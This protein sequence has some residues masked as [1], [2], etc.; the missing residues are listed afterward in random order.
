MG[1]N[2]DKAY[3]FIQFVASKES[4]G[5]ISPSE[6]NLAAELSQLTL[7]SEKEAVF[8]ATKKIGADMLPFSVKASV[9]PSAG[10]ITFPS[11][12]RHLINVYDAS[13]YRRYEE[14]TQ[15]EFP[16]AMKSGIVAPSSTYPAVVLR[17]DAIYI[18]PTN[19]T[20]AS[21]VEYLKKPSTP[22][23]AY[24]TVSSRPVYNSGASVNFD[25]DEILFLE[26]VMRMLPHVGINIKDTEL[27]QYGMSFNKEAQ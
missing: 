12:F 10:K 2:I 1:L 15:A 19:T 21:V 11:G 5:W 26:I 22:V 17:D 3:R 16:D 8:Q 4:K 7:Y 25:F 20:A 18:Y 24:T 23:W 9:T 27:A 6:Y 13:T 14:L